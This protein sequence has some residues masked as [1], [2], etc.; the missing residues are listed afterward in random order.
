MQEIETGVLHFVCCA[1]SRLKIQ[2]SIEIDFN[3]FKFIR[4]WDNYGNSIWI[5]Q[6]DFDLIKEKNN[7]TKKETKWFEI[8][9]RVRMSWPHDL[10]NEVVVWRKHQIKFK[11]INVRK[12]GIIYLRFGEFCFIQLVIHLEII[13]AHTG[14]ACYLGI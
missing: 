9:L 2:S 5:V 12:V 7:E 11:T 10:W 13:K 4:D 1:M 6:S 3:S 8:R 14:N